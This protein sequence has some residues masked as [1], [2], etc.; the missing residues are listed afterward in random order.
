M[1]T[2]LFSLLV[3][4]PGMCATVS[5]AATAL[6]IRE[7]SP[8]ASATAQVPVTLT[9]TTP[10][11]AMQADVLY[12]ESLYEVGDA[13]GGSQPDGVLV[14][15]RKISTGTLRVV[16]YH[17]S[18]APLA[19][20]VLFQVPL[21]AKAGVVN[22]DPIVLTGIQVA[23]QGGGVISSSLIKLRLVGLRNGG[24]MNGR[25]GIELSA[26]ASITNG[27]ISKIEYYVGGEKKG[28]GTG[29]N[30][31]F[32]WEPETSGPFEVVAIAFDNNDQQITSRTIP[33][34]VT[35]VGTYTSPVLGSYYGL[36]RGQAF[37]FANDGY[38]TMTSALSKAFTLK[39]LV[40]GKSWSTSGKFD[41][42]GNATA[43][44]KRGKGITDLTIVLA[45][46]SSPLVDQIHGRVA[47]GPFANGKFSG[48][49]FETEFTVNRV[50]WKTK[51][52]ESP[53]SGPYTMLIPAHVNAGT[54]AA[55]LGTGY[56]T[57]TVGKDG[58]A[59][60]AGSLADGT[61]I[62]ASSFVSKN[63]FWPLYASLYGNKGV[64]LGEVAFGDI[65]GI[66]DFS[67]PLTWMRPA[68][69]KAAMFKAGFGTTVNA[70]GSRFVK[71]AINQRLFPLANTGGNSLLFLTDGGLPA[72]LE[73]LALLTAAN[74]GII[75]TQGADAA[76]L[77]PAPATGLLSGAFIHEGTQKSVAYKGAVIQKQNIAAGYFL[78]GPLGGDMAFHENPDLPAGTGD[79]GPIGTNPLPVVKIS[80][81]A[82]KSTLKIVTGNKVQ[83]KGT[84]SD[85]QGISS[86]KIQ[87]L[88]NG[89]LSPAVN[90]VGTT[91]WTYDL[92]VPNGDGGLY[93]IF[94]KAIDSSPAA[95]ESEVLS[96][97]F[98]TPLKST[99]TVAVNDPA[100]GKVSTGFLGTSQRDV[101]KTFTITATPNSKKK[102]L[103]WTGSVVSTVPK[104]TVLMEAGTT[105]TANFGD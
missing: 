65:E 35:H 42:A 20:D 22:P 99:L 30:F 19:S 25:Q 80:A 34:I 40:G 16:I 2:H 57:V 32:L 64:I 41:D 55:P 76:T 13:A 89:V 1:R 74:K 7:A 79:D 103:G 39:L 37:N 27:S 6:G 63:G 86:V 69:T 18:G 31:T 38:V 54:Q 3:L 66:S 104:I 81:P 59:K 15:S 78:T 12:N 4:M 51:T 93:T 44:I 75:P 84:A 10:V 68:D 96:H 36:V 70:I 100:K 102:F 83:I 77:A 21:T 73:R 5:H 53:Q 62:T 28:E 94:A 90:A 52:N 71:P 9:S 91:S 82:A 45:Q 26:N 105:L 67:G 14:Q 92:D 48:N 97:P 58:S 88:H 87:V 29:N 43:T 50:T 47:D 60:L 85:K 72:D 49:T 95:D 8:E 11:V 46:S 56:G 98:W 101:G 24:A 17:R 61:T 23:G 33:V